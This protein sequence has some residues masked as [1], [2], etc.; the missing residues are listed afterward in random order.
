[1]IAF[2][3]LIYLALQTIIYNYRNKIIKRGKQS[4]IYGYARVSIENQN[5]NTQLDQL[6]NFCVSKIM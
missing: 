3:V 2:F 6:Q 1:M 5:V 4:M